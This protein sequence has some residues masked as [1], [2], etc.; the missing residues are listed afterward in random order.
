MLLKYL[1]N[2]RRSLEMPLINCQVELKLKWTKYCVLSAGGYENDNDDDN[3]IN[4]NN[5]TL[6]IKDTNIICSCCNFISCK[7][8]K[9]MK[10]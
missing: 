6:T 1:S 5:N 10:T 3:D 9:I 7:Q 8:L 2:F 4:N